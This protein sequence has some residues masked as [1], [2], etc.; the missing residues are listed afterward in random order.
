MKEI[1]ERRG[2]KSLEERGERDSDTVKK[3]VFGLA[4]TT[5]N[6]RKQRQFN[7]DPMRLL[8]VHPTISFDSPILEAAIN[9]NIA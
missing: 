2:Y 6:V 1:R 5:L 7:V 9:C 4:T 8:E 3:Q